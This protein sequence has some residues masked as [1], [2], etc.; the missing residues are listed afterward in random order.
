MKYK[1][2]NQISKREIRKQGKNIIPVSLMR[3]ENE[4][5]RIGANTDGSGK[6]IIYS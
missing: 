4:A 6:N 2:K 3:K 1:I 5:K